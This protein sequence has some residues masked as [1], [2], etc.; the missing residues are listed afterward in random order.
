VVAIFFATKRFEDIVA[1]PDIIRPLP[2]DDLKDPSTL[3][4]LLEKM[5]KGAK[6][7]TTRRVDGESRPRTSFR[8]KIDG[9][10]ITISKTHIPRF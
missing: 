4:A 5:E 2:S 9:S 10:I 1:Q 8:T 3:E 7:R 6:I